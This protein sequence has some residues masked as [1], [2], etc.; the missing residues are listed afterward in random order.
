V[1]Y[2]GRDPDAKVNGRFLEA[3]AS[4]WARGEASDAPLEVDSGIIPEGEL[5]LEAISRGGPD[6]PFSTAAAPA[7]S[8]GRVPAVRWSDGPK[9]RTSR[10]PRSSHPMK[11]PLSDPGR[12][13]E[14]I[15]PDT[16]SVKYDTPVRYQAGAPGGGSVAGMH[17]EEVNS[18]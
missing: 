17:L 9:A 8:F 14:D 5:A 15:Y 10:T 11:A 1:E 12:S 13:W 3:G 2:S 6:R 18:V 4:A 16:V 7:V